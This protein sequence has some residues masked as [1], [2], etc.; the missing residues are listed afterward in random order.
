MSRAFRRR[1]GHL[2]ASPYH[3]ETCGKIER[4]PRSCKKRVNLVVWET[5]EE[6]EA[7]IACFVAWYNTQRY[8]EAPGNLMPDDV[9]CG[10]RKG[11]LRCREKL[12]TQTLARRRRQNRGT[13]RPQELDR[14]QRPPLAPKA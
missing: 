5:P 11:I 8:H 4:Y 9:Y 12:E 14:A 13:P 10:R 7:E 3:P 2:L 1:L 6:L